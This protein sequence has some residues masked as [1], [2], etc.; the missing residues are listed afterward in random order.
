MEKRPYDDMWYWFLTG[1]RRETFP[2]LFGMMM[3]IEQA[4]FNILPGRPRCMHCDMPLA[5]PGGLILKPL[6]ARVRPLIHICVVGV[7]AA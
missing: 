7:R 1:E 2:K 6:G 3:D 4:I 5:G